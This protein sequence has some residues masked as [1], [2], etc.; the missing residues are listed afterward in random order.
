[1]DTQ[2]L[3][4]ILELARQYGVRKLKLGEL[5]LEL[6]P[7]ASGEAVAPKTEELPQEDLL[8]YSAK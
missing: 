1:M 5:E 7:V 4:L 3:A 2:Q 6:N 8:F